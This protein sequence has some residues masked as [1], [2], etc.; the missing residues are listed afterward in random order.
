MNDLKHAVPARLQILRQT[1]LARTASMHALADER[2][3]EV[4]A[5]GEDGAVDA[6]EG[7]GAVGVAKVVVIGH[8]VEV[9]RVVGGK[10]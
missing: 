2:H 7:A 10:A 5:A 6:G 8:G 4:A 9:A 3:G 1:E